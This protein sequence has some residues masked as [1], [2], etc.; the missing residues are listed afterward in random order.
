MNY[1]D[2][3]PTPN[4]IMFK[5]SVL[6]LSDIRTDTSGQKFRKLSV[7]Y[8]Y[9][10]TVNIMS[11]LIT[12]ILWHFRPQRTN[13]DTDVVFVSLYSSMRTQ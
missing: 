6:K 8:C 11:F 1:T 9:C 12:E 3:M 4:W 13:M 5:F 10:N 2:V 7:V